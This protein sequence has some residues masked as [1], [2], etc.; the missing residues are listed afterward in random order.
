[1]ALTQS[2]LLWLGTVALLA[3]VGMFVDMDRFSSIVLPFVASILWGITAIASFDVSVV[4][5]GTTQSFAF[6][7]LVY[8]ALAMAFGSA[9]LG[10]YELLLGGSADVE[11]SMQETPL[12]DR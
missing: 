7:E 12:F 11:E 9:L 3:N 1:M 2:A 10:I 6:V 5:G 8:P 4:S